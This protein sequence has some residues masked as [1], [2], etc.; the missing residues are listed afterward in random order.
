MI[1][2]EGRARRRG[3]AHAATTGADGRQVPLPFS[4]HYDAGRLD[5]RHLYTVRA[6]IKSGSELLAASDVTRRHHTG[7]SV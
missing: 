3:C 1:P 4:L 5:E 6:I 2:S 7:K